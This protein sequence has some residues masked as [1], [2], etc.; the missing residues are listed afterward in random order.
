M[1]KNA[2]KA[3]ALR[4]LIKTQIGISKASSPDR[5]SNKINLKRGLKKQLPIEAAAKMK[6]NKAR[7]LL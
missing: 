1:H 4:L 7:C 6:Q 2:F 3:A 5:E